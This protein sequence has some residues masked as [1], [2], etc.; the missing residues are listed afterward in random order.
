MNS[1]MLHTRIDIYNASRVRCRSFTTSG[2]GDV[3]RVGSTMPEQVDVYLLNSSLPFSFSKWQ[4]VC[5]SAV[6][7]NEMQD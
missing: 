5:T 6:V 1:L 3:A 7:S 4:A 2:H